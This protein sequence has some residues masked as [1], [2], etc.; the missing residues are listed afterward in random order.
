MLLLPRFILLDVRPTPPCFK[1]LTLTSSSHAG[2]HGKTTTSWMIR[3]I[4]EEP[5]QPG[6][7]EGLVGMIGS[8]EYAIHS[9]RLDDEGE[10]WLPKTSPKEDPSVGRSI[11]VCSLEL[12]GPGATTSACLPSISWAWGNHQGLRPLG[13]HGQASGCVATCLA[14]SSFL[15]CFQKN[16]ETTAQQFRQLH[17]R[18]PLLAGMGLTASCEG[19]MQDI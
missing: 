6:D 10:I 4:L 8:L 17:L 7:P 5:E 3:G 11:S 15:V 18:T 19:L 16:Q 13:M 2:T 14:D 9:D 12:L 1:W